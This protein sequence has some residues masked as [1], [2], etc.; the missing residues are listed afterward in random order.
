MEKNYL[1]LKEAEQYLGVS[2]K[3]MKKLLY[4]QDFTGVWT[5][6]GRVYRIN[7]KKL[8]EYMATHTVVKL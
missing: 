5:K 8:D 2:V 3:V 6:L 4:A 7:K 1:N